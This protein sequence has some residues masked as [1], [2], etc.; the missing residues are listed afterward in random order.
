M[1]V[2]ANVFPRLQTL[3]ILLRPLSKTRRFRIGISQHVKMSQILAKSPSV[4]LLC[5]SSF[6][7]KLIP[8]MSPL[9]LG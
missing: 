6:L 7:G 8:K 1:I 4:L 2:I 3:K 9:V 5:F